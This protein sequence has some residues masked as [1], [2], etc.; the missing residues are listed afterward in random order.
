MTCHLFAQIKMANGHVK[1]YPTRGT[2]TVQMLDRQEVPGMTSFS[3][4]TTTWW[5]DL[6]AAEQSKEGKALWRR[7]DKDKLPDKTIALPF[8]GAPGCATAWLAHMQSFVDAYNS[9]ELP[10]HFLHLGKW[11]EDISEMS[12]FPGLLRMAKQQRVVLRAPHHISP[13]HQGGWMGIGAPRGRF[14]RAQPAEGRHPQ[15]KMAT[16][17]AGTSTFGWVERV[18]LA[19][20]PSALPHTELPPLA[21]R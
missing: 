9:G 4:E 14:R 1:N 10:Q 12:V 8:P 16:G 5:G 6:A 7:V 19:G 15:G 11:P 18:R 13:A 3:H 21:R 17:W 2:L 20:S